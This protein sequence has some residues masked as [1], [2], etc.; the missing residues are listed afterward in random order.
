MFDLAVVLAPILV[1]VPGPRY[2][3]PPHPRLL[4]YHTPFDLDA[5]PV[6][7]GRGRCP[8]LP[9]HP[10]LGVAE[11]TVDLGGT[12]GSPDVE[13]LPVRQGVGLAPG[14]LPPP[15]SLRMTQW[16][17]A[18]PPTTTKAALVNAVN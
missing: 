18:T 5:A 7:L 3:D 16:T 17:I 13:D 1:G 4:L 8:G 14:H 2:G 11:K 15:R 6:Q 12:Q 10:A 9:G